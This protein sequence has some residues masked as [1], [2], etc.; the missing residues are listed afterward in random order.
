LAVLLWTYKTFNPK[1]N[2]EKDE[3]AGFAA[4]IAFVTLDI[5]LDSAKTGKPSSAIKNRTL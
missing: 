1:L 2:K 4:L 5:C 3:Y